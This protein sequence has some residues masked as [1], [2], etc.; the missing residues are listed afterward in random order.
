MTDTRTLSELVERR[1]LAAQR[2][3]ASWPKWMQNAAHF[4]GSRCFQ[5][6]PD[7]RMEKPND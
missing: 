2:E 5:W 4:E 3:V 7:A 1:I 6:H